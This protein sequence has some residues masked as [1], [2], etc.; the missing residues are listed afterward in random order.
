MV[1]VEKRLFD[2]PILC[3][4]ITGLHEQAKILRKQMD[5]QTE[6]LLNAKE[7]AS[8][9]YKQALVSLL[10]DSERVLLHLLELANALELEHVIIQSSLETLQYVER[11]IIKLYYFEGYDI[12]DIAERLQYS[13]SWTHKLKSKALSKLIDLLEVLECTN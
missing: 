1:D 8:A 13:Y 2:Y 9:E 3:G 12:S 10:Q 6:L 5:L 4:K 7:Y 11:K